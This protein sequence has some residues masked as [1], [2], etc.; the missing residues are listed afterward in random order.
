MSGA[1]AGPAAA[2]ALV[3]AHLTG[4]VAAETHVQHVEYDA[5]LRRWYVRFTC[6]G[7]DASTIYL[8]LGQ[9]S[10]RFELYFMPDPPANHEQLYRWLLRR[11]HHSLYGARFSLGSDGDVYVVG[12]VLYEHLTE[13]ELD[14]VIG[15]C[16]ELVETWFQPAIRIGFGR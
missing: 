1:L 13:E 6:E 3:E 12:R 14:R 7:R 15:V 4:P 10:L 9:R 11:N 5:P 16:Y 2:A 8:D